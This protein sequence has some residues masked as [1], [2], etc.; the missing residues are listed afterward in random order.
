VET[1]DTTSLAVQWENLGS[2]EGGKGQGK[3]EKG[4]LGHALYT[5]SWIAPKG[6]VH[7][8]QRW[9]Y[10]GQKGEVNVDQVSSEC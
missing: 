2:G 5:S 6:E 1:E 7:S 8:Q 10:M 9:F 3:G 4:S